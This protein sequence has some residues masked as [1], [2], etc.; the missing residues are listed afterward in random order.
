MCIARALL[1]KS[2]IIVLDEATASIDSATDQLIQQTVRTQFH[3]CT[4]LTI[5]HRIDTI[6]D[7]DR[8]LVMDKGEV[9]EYDTPQ[10]L[11]GRDSGVF[12]SL[13]DKMHSSHDDEEQEDES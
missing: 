7:Y 4:V 9:V 8:I 13:V 3:N 5:A 1:R 10:I 6:L 2:R 11:L 12:K